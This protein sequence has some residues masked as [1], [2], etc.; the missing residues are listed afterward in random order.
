MRKK[1][2]EDYLI[3]FYPSG[4]GNLENKTKTITVRA[5]SCHVKIQTKYDLDMLLLSYLVQ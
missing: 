1:A 2:M 5:V 4:N 3:E